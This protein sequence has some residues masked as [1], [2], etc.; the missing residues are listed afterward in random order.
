M[1]GSEVYVGRGVGVV[2]DAC[3]S[4]RDIKCLGCLARDRA[5]ACLGDQDQDQEPEGLI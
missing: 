1:H 2:E 4:G 3:T 5:A